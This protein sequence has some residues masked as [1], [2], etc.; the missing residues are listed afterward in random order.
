VY[1]AP[2]VKAGYSS[3][4]TLDEEE[5]SYLH[6]EN[7]HFDAGLDVKYNLTSNLTMDLTVNTDFAQVEADDQQVNLT[8]YS[9]YFPEKR[10]FFQERSSIFSYKL[11]GPSDMFYSRRIGIEDGIPVRIYGGAKV[12]GRAGKWDLGFL[13]MQTAEFDT[14]PSNNFGVARLRRQVINPNSYIG[15]LVTSKVGADGS[16]DLG[17]GL[18][19]IIRLFGDDYLDLKLAQNYNNSKEGSMASLKPTL[20]RTN[21][22]RR[23]DKGFAY[24]LTYSYFGEKFDPQMGFLKYVGVQGFESE[25]QYGWL[26]GND[27]RIFAPRQPCRLTG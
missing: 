21:W 19:G 16:F 3:E 12:I 4:Y 20:I 7:P 24:N 25:F 5:T 1:V 27:S 9:L 11:G 6:D 10:L 23:N 22:E 26:P 8:R 13:D 18:D 17:Y 15:G 14:A 2:Y